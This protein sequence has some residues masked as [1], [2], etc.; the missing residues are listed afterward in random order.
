[1]NSNNFT[2]VSENELLSIDGGSFGNYLMLTGGVIACF[3]TGPVGLGVG[4]ACAVMGFCDA[5]GW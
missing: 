2:E 1:M 5:Q 3:A 4:I